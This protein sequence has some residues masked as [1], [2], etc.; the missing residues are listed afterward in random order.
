MTERLIWSDL[1]LPWWLSGKESA[2][3]ARDTCLIP[4][5]GRSPGEGNGYPLQ[6]S[7][8]GNP[9]D[10]GAWWGTVHGVAKSQTWLTDSTTTTKYIYVYILFQ[11]GYTLLK[12]RGKNLFHAFQ[13]LTHSMTCSRMNT[14]STATVTWHSSLYVS[15]SSHG[16][17]L[18]KYISHSG[19]GAL[20]TTP[21]R[22]QW[23]PTPVLLPGK[24]HGRRSLV[25]CSPWGW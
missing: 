14:I 20:P 7:C 18:N 10:G 6:Y 3:N 1:M 24:S 2:C 5:S 4:G 22:R 19:L 21:W 23:H 13:F 11:K 9:M 15:G 25:G 8:L 17:F 12:A 16:H